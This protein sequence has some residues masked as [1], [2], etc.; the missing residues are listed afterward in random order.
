MGALFGT[1][2]TPPPLAPPAPAGP[3]AGAAPASDLLDDE[4]AAQL[5]EA[6]RER[7]RLRI[8]RQ[9]LVI[10]PPPTNINT[11]TNGASGGTGIRIGP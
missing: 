10:T 11:A 5:A 2:S 3:A 1:P 7:N 6:R 4:S 8:G 9:A